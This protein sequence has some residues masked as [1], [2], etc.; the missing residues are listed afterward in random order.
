MDRDRESLREYVERRQR[1]VEQAVEPE[2]PLECL[3]IERPLLE[4]MR[5][6][7]AEAGGQLTVVVAGLDSRQAGHTDE[8]ECHDHSRS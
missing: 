5:P 6:L 2:R 8:E 1:A 3:D 7:L 4:K